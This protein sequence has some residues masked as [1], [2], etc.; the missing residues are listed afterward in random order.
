MSGVL[1]D[2][3]VLSLIQKFEH[4]IGYRSKKFYDINQ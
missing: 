3:S 1:D 4:M 2:G